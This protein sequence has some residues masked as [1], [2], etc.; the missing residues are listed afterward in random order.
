M[1]S[2]HVTSPA[3]AS[4][5]HSQLHHVSSR[6]G[7]FRGDDDDGRMAY[8]NDNN[9]DDDDDTL[10]DGSIYTDPHKMSVGRIDSLHELHLQEQD[11]KDAESAVCSTATTVQRSS[12]FKS[13]LYTKDIQKSIE[14]YKDALRTRSTPTTIS[15]TPTVIEVRDTPTVIEVR[16]PPLMPLASTS[17]S[18]SKGVKRRTAPNATATVSSSNNPCGLKRASSSGNSG[19]S[20]LNRIPSTEKSTNTFWKSRSVQSLRRRPQSTTVRSSRLAPLQQEEIGMTTPVKRSYPQR[21]EPTTNNETATHETPTTATT[22]ASSSS[23][24]SPS[25]FSFVGDDLGQGFEVVGLT[26]TSTCTQ[27][28]EMQDDDDDD[29]DDSSSSSI[30]NLD[31]LVNKINVSDCELMQD[32]KNPG[33][34][35][36]T[37]EGLQTLERKAFS[38]AIHQNSNANNNHGNAADHNFEQWRREKLQ[39]K[40]YRTKHDERREQ[41]TDQTIRIRQSLPRSTS[42]KP[43]TSSHADQQKVHGAPAKNLLEAFTSTFRSSSKDNV[44]DLSLVP[45]NTM[46][47]LALP[48][49]VAKDSASKANSNNN[50]KFGILKLF[51]SKSTDVS[52]TARALLQKERQAAAEA[53]TQ[54]KMREHQEKQRIERNRQAYLEKE[55]LKESDTDMVNIRVFAPDPESLPEENWI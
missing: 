27:V 32:T 36:L 26:N 54:R 24:S 31:L 3:D 48:V 16:S 14:G 45:L 46:E 2:P 44:D 11:N 13:P 52:A 17:S 55:R 23:P 51:R 42:D 53:Q 19:T 5:S 25:S 34:L 6:T 39:K 35:R 41:L 12:L 47:D 9:Y 7:G 10:K 38:Q 20:N 4:A 49:V 22:T 43:R 1:G 28:L 8:N 29:D 50:N 18:S 21:F 40:W 37:A 30:S 15:T 33:V